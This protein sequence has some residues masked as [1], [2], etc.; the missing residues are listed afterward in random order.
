MHHI[1]PGRENATF[2]DTFHWVRPQMTLAY[3]LQEIPFWNDFV[4]NRKDKVRR[5]GMKSV[6]S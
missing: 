1:K 6:A 3:H 4:K 5:E 2:R